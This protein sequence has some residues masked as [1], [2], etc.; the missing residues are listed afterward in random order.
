MIATYTRIVPKSVEI[1]FK[2]QALEVVGLVEFN[3]VVDAY[4]AVDKIR[5]SSIGKYWR[6]R[7]MNNPKF[8]DPEKDL[9]NK[10]L[11]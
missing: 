2:G 6:L 1:C 7:L 4:R 5:S 8:N 9:I 3:S 11:R 10:W